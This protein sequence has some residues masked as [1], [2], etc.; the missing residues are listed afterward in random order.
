VLGIFFNLSLVALAC[1]LSTKNGRR[2]TKRGR[3]RAEED[4][5]D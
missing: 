1:A 3:R 5:E 2:E 4:G